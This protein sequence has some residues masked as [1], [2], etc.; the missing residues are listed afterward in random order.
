MSG[1]LTTLKDKPG[2]SIMADW[3]FTIEDLLQK[4]NI[5]LNMP[6][7]LQGKRQFTTEKVQ[8]GRKIASLRIHV[9][10]ELKHSKFYKKQFQSLW[11]VWQITLFMFVHTYQTSILV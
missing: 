4:L 3:G 8:E 9:E 5:E 6:P 7:F 11:L 1:F 10:R 2:I